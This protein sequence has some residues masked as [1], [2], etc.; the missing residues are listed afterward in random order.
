MTN[1]KLLADE[2]DIYDYISSCN[3]EA[4]LR[5]YIYICVCVCVCIAFHYRSTNQSSLFTTYTDIVSNLYI[6]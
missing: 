2:L 4:G 1:L 3:S 6:R 5:I